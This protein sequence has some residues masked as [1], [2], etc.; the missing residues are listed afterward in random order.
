MTAPATNGTAAEIQAER[1]AADLV[2]HRE[3][4]SWLEGEAPEWACGT[5]VDAYTRKEML[6]QSRTAIAKAEGPQQ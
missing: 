1:E 5:L 3:R 2:N 6:K 4:V